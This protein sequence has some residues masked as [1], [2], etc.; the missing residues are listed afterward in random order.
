MTQQIINLGPT[1]NPTSGDS[2]RVSFT[3]SNSNF[4][5]L[6]LHTVNYNNPHEV[7][8]AQVGAVSTTLLGV[9]N[10][11]ATL[12]SDGKLLSSQANGSGSSNI[13]FGAPVVT[14]SLSN[15]QIIVYNNS[16]VE[17]TNVSQV[18]QPHGFF[19]GN[20]TTTGQIIYAWVSTQAASFPYN[21]TGSIATCLTPPAAYA[22]FNIY[23]VSGGTGTIVGIINFNGGYSG[24]YSNT[25]MNPITINVGDVIYV[26]VGTVDASIS[27]IIFTLSGTLI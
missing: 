9:A 10:G 18:Y 1:N 19:A 13:N 14:N 23:H 12:G 7:T 21:F 22:N 6:Y 20:P 26:S 4:T 11:V 24:V 5:E 15:N 25:Q 3:K 17:W 16:L 2:I 8:A 27:T